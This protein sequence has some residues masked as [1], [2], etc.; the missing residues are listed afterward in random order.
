MNARTNKMT[1][2]EKLKDEIGYTKDAATCQNCEHYTSEM[3]KGG[4]NGRYA[5][6]KNIRCGKYGFAT[7]KTTVCD[8]H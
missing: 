6:E 3:T 1:K 2:L 7:K 8:S 5:I 4:Y